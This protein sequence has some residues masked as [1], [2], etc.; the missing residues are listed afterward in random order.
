M[1][2][3]AAHQRLSVPWPLT[4]QLVL[5][6]ASRGSASWTELQPPRI[7]EC[8]LHPLRRVVI[9]EL[10][11]DLAEDSLS[12][13]ASE[14]LEEFRAAPVHLALRQ[15]VRERLV[16]LHRCAH[17]TATLSPGPSA[18]TTVASRASGTTFTTGTTPIGPDS[19]TPPGDGMGAGTTSGSTPR[20]L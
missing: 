12:G 7:H 16:E 8:L 3:A 18:S 5:C 4:H 2:T 14:R 10:A 13:G 19:A 1:T 15:R 11:Q 20:R 6:M 17:P 9:E